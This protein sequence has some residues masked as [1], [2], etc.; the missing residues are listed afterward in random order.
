MKNLRTRHRHLIFS[1]LPTLLLST[2]LG[3]SFLTLRLQ[4]ISKSQINEGVSTLNNFSYLV[5]VALNNANIESINSI[6]YY[7]LNHSNATAVTI[8]NSEQLPV[9]AAGPPMS[10]PKVDGD[11]LLDATHHVSTGSSLRFSTPLN[12]NI[13]IPVSSLSTA[14]PIQNQGWLEVE[15]PSHATTVKRYQALTLVLVVVLFSWLLH[16]AIVFQRAYQLEN[17]INKF[18]QAFS[19]LKAGNLKTTIRIDSPGDIGLLEAE[20]NSM[21]YALH[22][23]QEEA[24]KSMQLANDDITETLETIEIQNIEL[25]IARKDAIKASATKSEFL[26]NMSHEIQI[27]LRWL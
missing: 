17:L 12:K 10:A 9:A 7:I 2:V 8:Y 16:L 15:I 5:Q 26:A 23:S 21:T 3:T 1:L 4:D 27:S 14:L 18:S 25:D 19:A 24:F 13:L 11:T 20:F 6:A 22:Q